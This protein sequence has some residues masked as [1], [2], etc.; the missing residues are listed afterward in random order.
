MN[1][2]G[3]AFFPPL[4]QTVLAT[5]QAAPQEIQQH[6]SIDIATRRPEMGGVRD[7]ESYDRRGRA[8]GLGPK[9]AASWL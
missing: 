7:R 4:A 6:I 3:P 2:W 1:D 8:L 9:G 5:L